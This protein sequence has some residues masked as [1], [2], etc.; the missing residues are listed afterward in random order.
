MEE[1]SIRDT[2]IEI[3]K[4]TGANEYINPIGGIG[5][6]SKGHFIKNDIDW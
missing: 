2:I 1:E 4:V 3:C 5:I 6:Y